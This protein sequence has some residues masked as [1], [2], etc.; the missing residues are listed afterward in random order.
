MSF[1]VFIGKK[2]LNGILL[3]YEILILQNGRLSQDGVK[4]SYIR[5]TNFDMISILT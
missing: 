2:T 3:K 5:S 1:L 4:S